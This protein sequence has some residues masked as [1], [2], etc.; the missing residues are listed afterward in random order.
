MKKLLAIVLV[1]S[2]FAGC[3]P[4]DFGDLNTNPL[5]VSKASTKSLLT[6]TLT[7]F[8]VTIFGINNAISNVQHVSKGPYPG[9]YGAVN[10]SWE[11]HYVGALANLQAIIDKNN[12]G[13]PTAD[14]TNGYR[15]NQLAVARILKAYYF[16]WLTDR[17]GDI[18]YSEALK[19]DVDFTPKYDAQKDIYYDLFKELKEAAAQIKTNEAGVAGDILLNGNM[20]RWKTFANTTRMMMALRLIKNDYEKGKAE[21][22]EAFAAGTINSNDDNVIYKF[23]ADDPNNFNP[24]YHS[25]VILNRNDYAISNTMTNYMEPKND[26]RL[27]VYG[28]DLNGQVVGLPYGVGSPTFIPAAYSRIGD[29]FRSAGSPAPV[30]TYA[31]VLFTLAEAAKVGY[32]AGG[33]A[34]A[35]TYYNDAIKASFQYYGVYNDTDYGN[36]IANADVAYDAGNGLKKIMSEKWVHLYLNGYEAWADWRRTG[37]P[38]LVPAVDGQTAEIPR[39]EGYPSQEA[40]INEENYN[41]ALQRQ[42]PNDQLTRFW[43]DK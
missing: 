41:E 29:F 22:A 19:G 26:P 33:D 27:F 12:N 40:A 24:W 23:I 7:K 2:L 5:Q 38:E 9:E 3:K 43:W 31:Q 25:H 35:E 20:E 18:P 15:D 39:R 4:G 30:Y 34:Q 13:D 6:N 11:A 16:W 8:N 10:V 17:Y 37:F 42:G 28:E 1:G 36:Y 21:F 14:L 32:I